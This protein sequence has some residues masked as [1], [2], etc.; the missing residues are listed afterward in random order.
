MTWKGREMEFLIDLSRNIL[1]IMMGVALLLFSLLVMAFGV[2]LMVSITADLM[3]ELK[4][5]GKKSE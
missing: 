1:G 3:D 5:R 2:V 4:K